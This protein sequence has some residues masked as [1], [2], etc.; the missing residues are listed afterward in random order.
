M[1]QTTLC[2][3]LKEDKV[4]LAMKKRGFGVGKWNGA[5]GKVIAGENI[6]TSALR[7]I[8]EEIGVAVANADLKESGTLEFYFEG[9]PEWDNFCH[10]FTAARWAGEPSESEEM[11]P[12]WYDHAE[13]PFGEMWIDDSH[14]LPLVLAGKKIEGKFIFDKTGSVL[15]DFSVRVIP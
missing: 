8:E 9:N 12:A 2:F 10:I 7:E 15:V 5:G 14:W 6:R 13:M 11:K 1:K 4:L 3:L